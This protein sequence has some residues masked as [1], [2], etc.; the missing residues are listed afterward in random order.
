[1][2]GAI[3]LSSP[4][5][6][7]LGVKELRDGIDVGKTVGVKLVTVVVGALVTLV[8]TGVAG[9]VVGTGVAGLVVGTGLTGLNVGSGL[10]C[11]GP[12]VVPGLTVGVGLRAESIETSV[13]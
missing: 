8:G 7:P 11:D 2:D 10:D 6:T 4:D 9:L 1:M 5:G 12:V 3:V 13:W